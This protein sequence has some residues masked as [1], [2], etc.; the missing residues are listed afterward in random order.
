MS[1]HKQ[2]IADSTCLSCW[3]DV[4]SENYVEYRASPDS[5]WSPSGFCE[6]CVNILIQSQWKK[7]TESLSTTN[8]KAEQRRL[9]ERGPPVNVSDKTAMPCPGGDHAEVH[10]LWYMS[11]GE[12]RSGKLEGSLEGEAREKYWQE[13]RAFYITDEPDDEEDDAKPA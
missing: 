8:C 7:Y 4:S 2:P 9:L 3:D 10:S 1:G 12:E 11:N 6:M 5:P 13:Q